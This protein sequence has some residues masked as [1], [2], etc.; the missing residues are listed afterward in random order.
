MG[1]RRLTDKELHEQR[2]GVAVRRRA[3]NSSSALS[4]A[5]RIQ[6]LQARAGNRATVGVIQRAGG[7]GTQQQ[8]DGVLEDGIERTVGTVDLLGGTGGT[9]GQFGGIVGNLYQQGNTNSPTA[10]AGSGFSVVGGLTGG[11]SIYSGSKQIDSSRKELSEE[12]KAGRGKE[13]KARGAKRDL[14]SGIANV[15]QGVLNTSSQPFNLLSGV[16]QHVSN[17]GVTNGLTTA[18]NTLGGIGGAIALPVSLL[19]SIRTGRKTIKQYARFRKLRKGVEDPETSASE[20]TKALEKQKEALTALEAT[21]DAALEELSDARRELSLAKRSRGDINAALAVVSDRDQVVTA[22]QDRIQQARAEITQTEQLKA[23]AERNLAEY[24]QRASTGTES[25]ADIRAYATAKNNAGWK[26]KLV[27]TVA[28][29]I[30]V[31]GG[32]AATLAAFAAAGLAAGVVVAAATP[33]GWALCGAAAVAGLAMAGYAFWKWA[34]KR[35]QRLVEGGAEKGFKT[36]L[37]SINPFAKDI[38]PSRRQKMAVRLYELANGSAPDGT[39]ADQTEARNVIK[40]LGLDWNG[41]KMSA[42]REESIK[43]IHAKMA[44]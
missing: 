1:S 7:T 27:G 32:L 43:L 6:R 26:K 35:Y 4:P 12:I 30:G 18:G 9:F 16:A 13:A 33:V 2:T 36:F 24:Q 5:E 20:A 15:T 41:L 39:P 25:P 29:F 22:L 21:Y 11:F 8:D 28:G 42:H 44:S 14:K 40:D 31:G 3:A 38:P 34:S 37:K 19:S 17:S 10:D 23:D